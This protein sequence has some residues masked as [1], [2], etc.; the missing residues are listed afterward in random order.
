MSAEIEAY[1]THLDRMDRER[2]A[3]EAELAKTRLVQENE[4]K[5]AKLAA[6]ESTKEMLIY[7]VGFLA[8]AA[9]LATLA[10]VFWTDFG[11][12]PEQ[13]PKVTGEQVEQQREERCIDTGGGWLPADTFS[14]SYPD[15]GMCIYPGRTVTETQN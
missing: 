13:Q 7:I 1:E 2:Q 5:R 8:A 14:G 3:Q 10:L 12:N 6:R 11:E 4:T 15:Q 9:V